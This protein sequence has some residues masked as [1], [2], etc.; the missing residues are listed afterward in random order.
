MTKRAKPE[1]ILGS[2]DKLDRL[3]QLRAFCAA[4][5]TQSMSRAAEQ[6]GVS[7]PS[8]SLHIR[9]LEQALKS[10]L[11]E[12]R[13]P[14]IMLTAEGLSLYEMA[15]PLVDGLDALPESFELR[16]QALERGEINIAAGESTILYLLP[17][18]VAEF[19]RRYPDIRLNLHNV[20]G[21]GGMGMLRAGEVDFAVGSMLEVPADIDYRPLFTFS[22]VLIAP[23]GHPLGDKAQLRLEDISPWGLILPP[24]RLTSWRLIDWIFQQHN[25]PYRVDL[26]VGGWEVI[27]RYVSLGLGISIVTSICLSG[28]NRLVLKDLSQYFPSRSYGLVCYRPKPLTVPAQRFV[29]VLVEFATGQA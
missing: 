20:T 11:F 27:K 5:R 10:Q 14:R 28:Q 7:Q 15:R 4:A 2:G 18:V 29:D 13:G 19:K 12:R 23:L 21:K 8:I 6:L 26:E 17:D 1:L 22:S 3:K 16:K 24:R 25:V 9:A